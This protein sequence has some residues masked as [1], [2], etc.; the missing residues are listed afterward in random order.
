MAWSHGPRGSDQWGGQQT[1]LAGLGRLGASVLGMRVLGSCSADLCA[2]AAGTLDAYWCSG[3]SPWDS[4]AGLLIAAEAGA[5]ATDPSGA[6]SAGRPVG[7]FLVAAPGVHAA[8]R[9][10]SPVAPN[11]LP[12]RRERVAP[13]PV[14]NRPSRAG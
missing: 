5:V 3:Q 12:R 7:A 2:V 10:S 9:R 8:Y 6:A 4:A 13:R 14:D 1:V 11:P